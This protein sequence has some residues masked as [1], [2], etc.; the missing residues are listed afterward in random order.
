MTPMALSPEMLHAVPKESCVMQRATMIVQ[1]GPFGSP[2]V[3]PKIMYRNGSA[4]MMDPPG[5]PGDATIAIPKV[6]ING[7][8]VFQ[9]Q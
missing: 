8:T 3:A 2:A 4:V 5:A 9:E 7:M 6:M 1:I